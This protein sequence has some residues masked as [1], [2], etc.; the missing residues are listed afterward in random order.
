MKSI[1]DEIANVYRNPFRLRH[2]F[3]K[4][5]QNYYNTDWSET[6]FFYVNLFIC[7]ELIKNEGLNSHE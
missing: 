2:D 6:E 1:N 7:S 4:E 3:Y 5:Y